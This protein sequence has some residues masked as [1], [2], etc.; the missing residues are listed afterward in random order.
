MAYPHYADGHSSGA[1]SADMESSVAKN[2]GVPAGALDAAVSSFDRPNAS[3]MWKPNTA[4]VI[5]SNWV[6]WAVSD[7]GL[8]PNE[9]LTWEAGTRPYMVVD[10]R[11]LEAVAARQGSSAVQFARCGYDICGTQATLWRC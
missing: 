6:L 1:G 2:A 8:F 3:S 7:I 4:R 10:G 9:E 11:E 5:R